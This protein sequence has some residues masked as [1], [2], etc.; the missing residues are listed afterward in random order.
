MP[1]S[2]DS[3][4]IEINAKAQSANTA[5]DRLV[6]KLDRLNS[7][8]RKT[9]GANLSS[10]ANGV[11]RLGRAMQTMNTVKTAD[12]T[13]LAKNLSNLNN[14]D[15]SKLSNLAV[16][17]NRISTSFSGLSAVSDSS[18]QLAEL[19]NGISRLGYK[20]SEKAI[21][22]IPKLADS[23]NRLMTVLSK[24]PKVSRNVIDLTNALANLASKGSRMGTASNILSKGLNKASNSAVKAKKSFG[25][26]ASAFG[27]FYATYWV[28]IRAFGKLGQSINIASDL[29]EVQNVVDAT[30]GKYS[31]LVDKMAKTSI[32]EFG[33][34]ELTVKQISSRFQ[35]MG[36]AMGFAQGKMA[37]MSLE[38]TALTADMASFY[39]M[40]QK[41][42][43]EDLE[44][45]FTGQTRPMRTYGIDLTQATLK[46]WA[47]SQGMNANIESMTQA[48]KTMLRYQYT[49]SHL[50]SAQGDFART[51][52]RNL[53]VA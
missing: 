40:E 28:L 43:A 11:D 52:D 44:A 38:L 6:G 29:T 17:V 46:E 24:S 36:T 39:N 25:G 34:S 51:S 10:L 42:V 15:S 50:T 23:L 19:A 8:L 47:L 4:Q 18:K 32:P 12:F 16:N 2:I 7:S 1:T 13:R 37:D 33:M 30:F 21:T 20:S 5:I 53:R 27:K 48:E 26:L 35:A 9:D 45:I 3:L 49:I 41:D 22:N 14:L 31:H